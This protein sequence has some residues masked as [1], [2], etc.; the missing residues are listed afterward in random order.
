MASPPPPINRSTFVADDETRLKMYEED[1]TRYQR[2][3]LTPSYVERADMSYILDM[4]PTKDLFIQRNMIGHYIFCCNTE[5]H[6][7][8]M[9]LIEES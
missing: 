9:V 8:R 2:C 7:T 1:W 6:E 4:S 3:R 5:D